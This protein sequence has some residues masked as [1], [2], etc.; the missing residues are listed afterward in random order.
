MLEFNR[1]RKIRLIF[2]NI[3]RVKVINGMC[4]STSSTEIEHTHL[5]NVLNWSPLENLVTSKSTPNI[6]D[7]NESKLKNGYN[8]V[9][10]SVELQ[11][12]MLK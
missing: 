7:D 1:I 4:S 3:D 2:A 9:Q 11:K 10:I 5:L 6:K 8:A 12:K